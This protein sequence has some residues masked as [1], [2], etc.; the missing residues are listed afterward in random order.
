MIGRRK[1]QWIRNAAAVTISAVLLAGC[2]SDE[3]TAEDV[4]APVT[5]TEISGSVGH[6]PVIGAVMRLFRNDGVEL[7]A[8]ESD[9]SANYSV[10]VRTDESYYP[11]LI[12][13]RNGIDI[14]TNMAPDF[15][16]LGAVFEP[17]DKIVA[18]VNPFSTLAV[19]LAANMA[20]G[21]NKINLESAQDIV[22]SE[23]NN[24]LSSLVTSGPMRTKIDEHNIAEIVRAS[25]ALSETIL[26]TRDAISGVGQS[27]SGDVAVRALASDLT[28]GVVDGR[29]GP[30]SDARHAAVSTIVAA[31]VALETMA[32]ELHVN[33]IDATLAM[34]NAIDQ[35]LVGTASPMLSELTVT[36]EML[37][38]TEIGLAA[39]Y[40]V[41]SDEKIRELL[42]LV[43]DMQPGMASSTI[44]TFVLPS[45]YRT[46]LDNAILLVAGGSSDVHETVNDIS[47]TGNTTVGAGNRAP[48]ISGSP[49]SAVVAGSSYSF[50]PTASDPE[51]DDLTFSISGLPAWASFDSATGLL[52]G[53]PTG[54]DVG[55]YQ[56]IVISV[57]DGEFSDS[58]AGFAI[59]VGST[60]TNSAP[61][62]SGT[63]LTN[64]DAGSAY[65]F[66][67]SATDPERDVLT[68]SISGMPVWASFDSAIGLLSGTPTGADVGIYQ[69]IVIS[70]SD[71]EFSDSLA[72]F[73]ITVSSTVTNSAPLI[74]GTAPASVNAGSAY[75]FTPTSSDPDGDTLTFSVSGLPMWASF[76]NSTG[77]IGGTPESG[78]IGTYSNIVIDVTDGQAS[79]SLAAFS[80][81][82]DAVSLGSV[83]LSWT[84]PTQNTDGTTLTD[85][86][87]YRIYWGT[88]PGNYSNSVRINN[89]SVST[90][91]VDNL[92]PGTYEFVAT[93]FNT[94]GVESSYSGAATKVV[95]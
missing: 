83:T 82:V 29:G 57:S 69:N 32:N 92:V 47:R 49:V 68:F 44:K 25:E 86:A 50:T 78:D 7:M 5:D 6:G 58:L 45:D 79:S 8:V 46:R 65:S 66:T 33:G 26:R 39:A 23:F 15:T 80:I 71:G 41:T 60:L 76:N 72:A 14:V 87:G 94:A 43:K 34:S 55:S 88:S 84:P 52:S 48:S 74:S 77:Q 38:R 70:V 40:A 12:D 11:L 4:A 91:V 51:G 1:F 19:E 36:A 10:V 21:P 27:T 20:G 95:P 17:G 37:R 22:S 62:I 56:N 16:L 2:L 73:A 30:R 81:T 67:P 90:Y 42:M 64:I 18:N 53:T 3:E 24:G 13:A 85:L 28:D 93:A 59:I 63:P 61:Q 35:V 31:Q 75:S 89:A 9:A 54:A